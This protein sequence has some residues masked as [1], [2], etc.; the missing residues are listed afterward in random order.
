MNITEYKKILN[1]NNIKLFDHDIRLSYYII[2]NFYN[3]KMTG[4]GKNNISKFNNK[5]KL[6]IENIV[7][8]SLS[9]NFTKLSLI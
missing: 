7:N 8:L 2:N 1:K 9:Y 3:K 5:S 6:E 4:G